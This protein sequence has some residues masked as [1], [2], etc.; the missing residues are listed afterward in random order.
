MLSNNALEQ[1]NGHRG[2]AVLALGC[3]LAGT[4]QAGRSTRTL[5]HSIS[6]LPGVTK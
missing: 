6:Q 5:G 3:V 4:E 1:T 2:G